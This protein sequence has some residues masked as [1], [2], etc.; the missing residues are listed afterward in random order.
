[1]DDKRSILL[2]VFRFVISHEDI[3]QAAQG[4]PGAPDSFVC[5]DLT[6][7][8]E[9]KK[10]LEPSDTDPWGKLQQILFERLMIED[11]NS[12]ELIPL[13]I[14]PNSC[15]NDF[16]TTDSNLLRYLYG[17]FYRLS[18]RQID[19]ELKNSLQDTI[20]NQVILYLSEPDVF[21]DRDKRYKNNQ[22]APILLNIISH[23]YS[24]QDSHVDVI[25]SFVNRLGE[26][27]SSNPSAVETIIAPTYTRLLEKFATM[28][29]DGQ[30]LQEWLALSEFSPSNLD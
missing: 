4:N 9:E 3:A 12:F 7:C 13:K 16:P 29:I 1:M 5:V 26:A 28:T 20:L 2:D 24:K 18:L 27:G 14:K 17:C 19:L 23:Y 25:Q 11:Y 6:K 10:I 8:L 21:P 30:N 22:Q 15:C